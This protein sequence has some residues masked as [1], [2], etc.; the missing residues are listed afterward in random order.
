MLDVTKFVAELHEYIGKAL[1]P[2]GLRL[3]ALESRLPEKGDP[4]SDGAPG[5]DGAP[6]DPGK[7]G[8][9]ADPEVIRAMVAEAVAEIP[10]PQDGKSVDPETVAA[11]VAEQVDKCMA[12]LT[13]P[14]NGRDGENGKDG[15]SVTVDDVAPMLAD[16]VGKAVANIPVPANGKDGRDGSNGVTLDEVKGWVSDLVEAKHAAW[17]LDFERRAHGVL[18]RAVE[19]IPKPKD[20]E[21]GKSFDGALTKQT[22]DAGN[23]RVIHRWFV[24]EHQVG[25][26]EERQFVDR[27]VWRDDVPDYLKYNG[28]T[29]G[30]SFWIAQKDSPSGKPGLSADWRLAVKKGRDSRD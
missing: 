19:R 12:E 11:M 2:V 7:D 10:K 24:G 30:G 21:D 26:H 27:G 9:D 25:E 8:K 29:F 1:Q 28:V 23:G 4:G 15:T 6:G 18:E 3:K 5:K 14:E 17:A 16:L 20:G 13:P 22:E